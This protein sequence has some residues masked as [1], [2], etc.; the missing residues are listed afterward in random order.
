MTMTY[1]QNV[2]GDKVSRKEFE[3]NGGVAKHRYVTVA[4]ANKIIE[5]TH[6][7]IAAKKVQ[8]KQGIVELVPSL[9]EYT[10]CYKGK[11][12]EE[13]IPLRKTMKVMF[14]TMAH[15]LVDGKGKIRKDIGEYNDKSIAFWLDNLLITSLDDSDAMDELKEFMRD[16]FKPEMEKILQKDYKAKS[17]KEYKKKARNDA[18][19]FCNNYLKLI[20]GTVQDTFRKFTSDQTFEN[21]VNQSIAIKN[22]K[23]DDVMKNAAFQKLTIDGRPITKKEVE[24]AL[25]EFNKESDANVAEFAQISN[26]DI[27]SVEVPGFGACDEYAAFINIVLLRSRIPKKHLILCLRISM[28]SLKADIIELRLKL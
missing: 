24:D 28:I 8:G 6:G 20:G 4:E 12:S 9:P 13:R 14:K 3:E 16:I 23:A 7:F 19:A 26:M 15:L 25:K 11:E 17:V 21:F 18:E 10:T 5:D 27:D 22:I 1:E 2:L